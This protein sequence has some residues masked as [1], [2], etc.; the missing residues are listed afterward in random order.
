MIEAKEAEK[1]ARKA[2]L[3]LKEEARLQKEA[4]GPIGEQVI[5]A[6]RG[7]DRGSG[8]A[9]ITAFM[10]TMILGKK[11]FFYDLEFLPDMKKE[12]GVDGMFVTFPKAPST[13]SR[14]ARPVTELT[15]TRK[16][17]KKLKTANATNPPSLLHGPVSEEVRKLGKHQYRPRKRSIPT[18]PLSLLPAPATAATPKV[19]LSKGGKMRTRDRK[20]KVP[21]KPPVPV[22]V[23]VIETA[24]V[25]IPL[26]TP[27]KPAPKAAPVITGPRITPHAT[28]GKVMVASRGGNRR[29]GPAIVTGCRTAIVMEKEIHFY[30]VE[31]VSDKKKE[32][33][34]D[35]IFVFGSNPLWLSP[36]LKSFPTAV[37]A[38]TPPPISNPPTPTPAVASVLPPQSEGASISAQNENNDT[39][40]RQKT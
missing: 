25:P 33:G 35:G 7:G 38:S 19:A 20:V 9:I 3:D 32:E 13:P 23:P 16:R 15:V 18:K 27:P 10:G 21:K 6:P 28:G 11:V 1:I 31:F 8:P 30:D 2:V 12:R 22:P 14:P 4:A 5:V 34:I 40:K 36:A 24:P 39:A 26:R 17:S 37:L 29:R